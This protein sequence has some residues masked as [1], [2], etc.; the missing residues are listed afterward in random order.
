MTNT[1]E[2]MFAIKAT[3]AWDDDDCSNRLAGLF[4]VN[5]QYLNITQP[6]GLEFHLLTPQTFP[7]EAN[8]FWEFTL[9]SFS[10]VLWD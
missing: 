2:L 4:A 1:D 5:P 6:V 8:M 9:Y 7:S 10:V 3:L